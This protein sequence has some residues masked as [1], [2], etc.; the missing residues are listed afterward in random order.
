MDERHDWRFGRN[1]FPWI[2]AFGG[3]GGLSTPMRP[4]D[5]ERVLTMRETWE[6]PR[7]VVVKDMPPW[8]NV[9]DLLWSPIG[10]PIKSAE[11]RAKEDELRQKLYGPGGL[12]SEAQQ[13]ASLAQPTDLLGGPN[14]PF[15]LW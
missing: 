13:R 3:M 12:L 10:N 4:N 9:A 8:A 6:E 7:E 2:P 14:R 11:Q 5:Y 15:R 1:W